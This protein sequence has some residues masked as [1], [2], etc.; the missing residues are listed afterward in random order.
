MGSGQGGLVVRGGRGCVG[1]P[2]AEVEAWWDG[3]SSQGRGSRGQSRG[4]PDPE[5]RAPERPEYM[6]G[7]FFTFTWLK[8][9]PRSTKHQSDHMQLFFHLPCKKT[10]MQ[11]CGKLHNHT[12]DAVLGQVVHTLDQQLIL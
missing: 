9:S 2:V 4:A 3:N 1:C 11:C 7:T 5:P 8:G 6:C 12:H 10:F